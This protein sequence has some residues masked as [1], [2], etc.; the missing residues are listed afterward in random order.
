[1]DR[2]GVD[3]GAEGDPM[4]ISQ[5]IIWAVE[6][7]SSGNWRQSKQAGESLCLGC[8]EEAGLSRWD[9]GR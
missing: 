6:V 7:V 9:S 2:G 5:L 3:A 4:S 1:M 8:S